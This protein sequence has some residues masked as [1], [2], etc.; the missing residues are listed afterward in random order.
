[1][2][3]PKQAFFFPWCIRKSHPFFFL[4]VLPGQWLCN[5][6]YPVLTMNLRNNAEWTILGKSENRHSLPFTLEQALWSVVA[7]T[8]LLF[9]IMQYAILPKWSFISHKWFMHTFIA[10]VRM[11]HLKVACLLKW[12]VSYPGWVMV[13]PKIASP[14]GLGRA[15][16]SCGQADGAVTLTPNAHH[17]PLGDNSSTSQQKEGLV[18]SWYL[19]KHQ[20]K[21]GEVILSFT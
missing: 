14:L 4:H 2:R 10:H 15:H 17:Q 16:S 9:L 11:Q 18:A 21:A 19:Q 3:L 13:P 5:T 12:M 8:V 6:Y 20:P 1:M 7:N